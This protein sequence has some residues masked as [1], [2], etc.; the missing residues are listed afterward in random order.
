MKIDDLVD[1]LAKPRLWQWALGCYWLALV[2]ST[3]IP[4]NLPETPTGHLD[5]LYHLGAF[6]V[7]A[8]LLATNLQLAGGHVTRR[9]FIWLWIAVVAFAAIDE[10]TQ[11]YFHRDASWLDWLADAVGAALGLA[12]FALVRSWVQRRQGDASV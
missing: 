9:H 4:L 8:G 1:R 7:L 10:L 3:H 11:P 5:K 6:T 2:I 12:L